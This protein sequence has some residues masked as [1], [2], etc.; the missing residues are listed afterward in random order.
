MKM[1]L[2]LGIDDGARS[3]LALMAFPAFLRATT[4]LR[5]DG[6]ARAVTRQ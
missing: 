5:A 2:V 4:G 1:L 6:Y 3:A